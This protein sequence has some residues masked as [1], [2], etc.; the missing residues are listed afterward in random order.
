MTEQVIGISLGNV[1]FSAIYALENG[2]RKSKNEGYKTCPFDLMVSNYKGIVECLKDDFLYFCDT[3]YLTDV[4]RNDKE[5][6]IFN[7]KYNFGF[8][9]ESPF[10]ANLCFTQKW[11]EGPYHYVNN[12]F[13]HFIERYNKRIDSFRDYLSNPSNYIIFIIQFCNEP[14]PDDNLDGL[15]EALRIHYPNL[16][17]ELRIIYN[18]IIYI[19]K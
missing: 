15:K 5:E 7:T 19:M 12:N 17:Y 2:L 1:C 14:F 3:D 18:S 10:H 11:P 6:L 13:Q 16:R 8:N 4:P 9:H